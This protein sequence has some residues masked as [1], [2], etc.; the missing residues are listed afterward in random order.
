MLYIVLFYLFKSIYGMQINIKIL[1]DKVL[2]CILREEFFHFAVKLCCQCF[3]VRKYQGWFVELGDDIR[4]C[5]GLTR[6]GNTKQSLELVAFFEAF[7]Q[8]FDGL[9]LIACGFVFGV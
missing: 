7:D 5:E 3:I 4:H 9:W 2:D 8:F 1:G 6:T